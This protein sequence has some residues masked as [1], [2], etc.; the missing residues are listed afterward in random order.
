VTGLVNA[1]GPQ[2]VTFRLFAPADALCAGAPVFTDV[3]PLTFGADPSVGTAQSGSFTP[4]GAGTYRWVAT[5]DG[6]VNNAAVSGTCGDPTE[7]TDVAQA[8]PAI[9]TVASPGVVVGTGAL[10]DQ[11][12]VTG[13]VNPIG[14]QTV[15]FRLYGPADATCAGAAVFTSTAPVV[16][17]TAQSASFAPIG[18]GTYR[19]VATYDGDVNNA[20][21]SRTC[22]DPTETRTASEPPVVLP[23]ETPPPVTQPPALLPQT[24]TGVEWPLDVASGIL[25]AGSLMAMLARRRRV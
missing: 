1:V 21:V 12:T 2:T 24:G 16:G 19:W 5:Y 18:A 9:V 8:T 6:D 13:R 22:G 4:T 11:A 3:Q 23:P 7:T 10:S 17:D 15:T 20:A 25:L 14:A